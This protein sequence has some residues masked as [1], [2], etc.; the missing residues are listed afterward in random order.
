MD[1]IFKLDKFLY[2]T[3]D[4]EKH[5]LSIKQCEVIQICKV[6]ILESKLPPSVVM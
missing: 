3:R 6:I 2:Q 4:H 5:K 1:I